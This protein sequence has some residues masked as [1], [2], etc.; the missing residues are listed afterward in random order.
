MKRYFTISEFARLRNININSLR[1]YERIGVLRPALVD[2][3]TGYRFYSPEQLSVLDVI[4]LCIDFGMPLKDLAKFINNEGLIQNK[5]LFETGKKIAQ[6]RLRT[7]QTELDKIEYTLQYMNVNQKYS[8]EKTLYERSIPDR[9]IITSDFIGDLSDAREIE[10]KSGKLYYEAQESGLSPVFPA[11]LILQLD[12][13][14][15]KTKLFFEI[16]EQHVSHPM[17]RKLPAGNFL[18]CQVDL[19]TGSL[20]QQKINEIYG[21]GENTEIVVSNML[22][23]RYQIGSKKSELQ[24]RIIG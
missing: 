17:V 21:T 3:N 5:E 16:M 7:L 2:E 1:Y 8:G 20:S 6:E 9:M 23:N 18:C 4:L 13:A 15:L 12:G 24:K 11:G 10:M 22:L 14:E 19:A